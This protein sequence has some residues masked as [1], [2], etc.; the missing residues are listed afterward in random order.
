MMINYFIRKINKDRA[1]TVVK[2]VKPYLAK[3][4]KILDIGSGSGYIASILRSEGKDVVPV[5][6]ADFH[7]PILISPIIY[8]GIKLPFLDK[9][10]DTALLLMVLHHTSDPSIVFC[11]AMRVAK[12]IVVIET[13]YSNPV[14]RFITIV[15]DTVGNLRTR[16]YWSSYKTDTQWKSFFEARGYGVMASHKYHDKT[17]S[18]FGFPVLHI[19]YYLEAKPIISRDKL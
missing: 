12:N 8:D 10:F 17:L 9:S 2:R 13:S 7:G 16:A 14:N 3:S 11:E 4:E 1:A 5:D 6:V 19:L 18:R 15:A